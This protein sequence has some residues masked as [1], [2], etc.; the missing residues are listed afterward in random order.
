M[1]EDA[2]KELACDGIREEPRD[3]TH[4]RPAS[5]VH[6]TLLH[7]REETLAVVVLHYHLG[8]F[9]EQVVLS[10]LICG[11]GHVFCNE[12]LQKYIA[13]VKVCQAPMCASCYIGWN[14]NKYGSKI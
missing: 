4:H 11:D 5:I 1:S 9:S 6:F 8:F 14:L 12:I 13:N 3:N 10:V 7:G 2:E